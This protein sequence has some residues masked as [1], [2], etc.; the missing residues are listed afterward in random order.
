VRCVLRVS[1][2]IAQVL[3]DMCRCEIMASSSLSTFFQEG[4]FVLMDVL[5]Y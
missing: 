3:D 1:Q 2:T 4:G 5:P